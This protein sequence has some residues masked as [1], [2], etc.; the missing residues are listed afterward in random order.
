MTAYNT[1]K[2]EAGSSDDLIR[3]ATTAE[4]SPS[5]SAVSPDKEAYN[6]DHS[7]IFFFLWLTGAL[8]LFVRK[9]TV[10]QSFVKYV[11][12]GSRKTSVCWR[13]SVISWN[14]TG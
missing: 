5:A 12:A 8:L 6:E 1:I 9:L 3:D 11:D 14:R 2:H 4:N 13:A 7:Q 10:Y